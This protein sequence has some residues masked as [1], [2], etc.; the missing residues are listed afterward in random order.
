MPD[1]AN[2]GSGPKYCFFKKRKK[3][4]CK[5]VLQNSCFNVTLKLSRRL[6]ESVLLLNYA[7]I[8]PWCVWCWKVLTL[9]RLLHTVEL[10]LLKHENWR[11]D[12]RANLGFQLREDMFSKPLGY[13]RLLPNKQMG[14]AADCS[15]MEPWTH[16]PC[17]S[18]G[19]TK[20]DSHL[21]TP[22]AYPRSVPSD[23]DATTEMSSSELAQGW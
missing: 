23:S 14:R 19:R 9:P 5:I 4:N 1:P 11:K 10:H 16:D 17:K 7:F 13:N 2:I 15:H 18:E 20:K 21:P 3:T 8:F 6:Q 22:P 12:V